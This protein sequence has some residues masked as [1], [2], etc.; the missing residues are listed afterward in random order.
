[1]ATYFEV[2][3]TFVMFQVDFVTFKHFVRFQQLVKK[4]LHNRKAKIGRSIIGISYVLYCFK[5]SS[6]IRGISLGRIFVKYKKRC[7]VGFELTLIELKFNS[8]NHYTNCTND[9]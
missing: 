8:S 7:V 2:V 6:N 1:M 3:E 9:K 5:R 4:I